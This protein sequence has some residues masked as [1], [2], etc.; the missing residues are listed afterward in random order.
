MSSALVNYV[1]L[2]GWSLRS[3]EQRIFTMNQLVGTFSLED[4]N[5]LLTLGRLPGSIRST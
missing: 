1:A 2:L 4:V 3:T 5:R